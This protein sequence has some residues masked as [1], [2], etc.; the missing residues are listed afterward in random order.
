M[1]KKIKACFDS[2]YVWLLEIK[3]SSCS[4]FLKI[5]AVLLGPGY[6]TR[7]EK[8]FLESKKGKKSKTKKKN[9]ILRLYIWKWAWQT[10]EMNEKKK[11]DEIRRSPADP[12]SN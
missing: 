12:C 2:K 1:K 10:S 4:K 11:F 6:M 8:V 7:S 5:E 9:L 3:P